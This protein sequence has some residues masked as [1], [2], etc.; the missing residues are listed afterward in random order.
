MR[1]NFRNYENIFSLS[2]NRFGDNFLRPAIAVHLRSVNQAEAKLDSQTQRRD[3]SGALSFAF[4]HA[5]RALAKSGNTLAVAKYDGFHVLQSHP[6]NQKAG[7]TFQA[8]SHASP[9]TKLGDNLGED[10]AEI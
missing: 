8:D 1:I 7:K 9:T 5:P 6:E 10:S 4:A 2:M 3:F